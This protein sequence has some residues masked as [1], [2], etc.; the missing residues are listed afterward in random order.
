MKQFCKTFFRIYFFKRYLYWEHK[1]FFQ[2]HVDEDV[3][4]VPWNHTQNASLGKAGS[5]ISLVCQYLTLLSGLLVIFVIVVHWLSYAGL[6]ATPWT[7]TCQAPLSSIMSQSLLKFL[8]IESVMPSN[9]L[10]L[11]SPLL[12]FAFNPCYLSPAKLSSL[13][14]WCFTPPKPLCLDKIWQNPS[15]FSLPFSSFW[16]LSL[17]IFISLLPLSGPVL[18]ILKI[19]A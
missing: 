11:C 6:F 10:I 9:H 14:S 5:Y 16:V 12:L 13:T 3:C 7:A 18:F 2:C 15:N 1:I 17:K 8:S 4:P 19:S